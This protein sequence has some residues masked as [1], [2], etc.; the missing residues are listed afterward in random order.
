MRRSTH[1]AEGA[2]ADNAIETEQ[3]ERRCAVVLDALVGDTV[4]HGGRGHK[5]R[6]W[7]GERVMVARKRVRAR[8][9]MGKLVTSGLVAGWTWLP[10]PGGGQGEVCGVKC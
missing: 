10:C 9:V 2:L 3:V 4:A 8:G 6:Q 7:L 1:L 5:P